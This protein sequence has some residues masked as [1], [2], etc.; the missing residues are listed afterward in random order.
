MKPL[1]G[2]VALITGSA[3]GIGKAIAEKLGSLGARL[4]ISDILGDLA[5]ETAADLTGK[6]FESMAAVSDVTK[7][8]DVARLMKE[9]TDHFG[10]LDILVNNAGITRDALLIRQTP[11]SWDMVMNINLKGAFLTTQ[12][13]S[14]IMMKVRSGKIINISSVVGLMGNAGQSN[15]SASKAGLVG[16]TKSSAKELAG[17]GITVNAVAPGYIA[18]QMTEELP[19]AAKE[20]FLTVIP[21]KRPGTGIDV[22]GAVAFL[23]SPDADYITGQVIQVDGGMLM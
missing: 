23:A 18:T 22:A 5:E 6:G 3:R 12:A 21:L 13:A 11:E 15:Y 1:D 16:L 7:S 20:A 4:V 14:R 19:E 17:R 2:K 8:E 9:V 10:R